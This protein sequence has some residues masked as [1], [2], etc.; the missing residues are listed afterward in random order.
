MNTGLLRFI[1]DYPS[2]CMRGETYA[3]SDVTVTIG[4]SS[5]LEG[6]LASPIGTILLETL[7]GLFTARG[8]AIG[9]RL[10]ASSEITS[11]DVCLFTVTGTVSGLDELFVRLEDGLQ[12]RDG[13]IVE[14]DAFSELTVGDSESLLAI[15]GLPA[16][17]SASPSGGEEGTS[18]T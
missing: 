6:S 11:I 5:R 3:I 8:F 7:G 13:D 1:S 12:L 14:E 16:K 10:G 2:L 15:T 9:V 18:L 17:A 4:D